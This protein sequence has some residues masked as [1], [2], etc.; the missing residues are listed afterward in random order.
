[1]GFNFSRPRNEI[2]SIVEDQDHIDSQFNLSKIIED[3]IGLGSL[4]GAY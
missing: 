4:I 3:A 2:R 1:M